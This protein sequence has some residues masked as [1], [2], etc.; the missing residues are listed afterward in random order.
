MT[1]NRKELYL[2]P[3]TGTILDDKI[4]GTTF[5]NQPIKRTI[6]IKYGFETNTYSSFTDL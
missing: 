4:T 3:I 6:N 5:W 2:T 1:A